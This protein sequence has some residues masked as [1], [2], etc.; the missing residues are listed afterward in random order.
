M[1]LGLLSFLS[2]LNSD[3]IAQDSPRIEKLYLSTDKDTYNIGEKIHFS[4]HLVHSF[5]LGKMEDASQ[6][7]YVELLNSRDS[8]VRRVKVKRDSLGFHNSLDLDKTM[9][10]GT[11]RL[12]AYTRWMMNFDPG[13]MHTKQIKIFNP[14]QKDHHG[15]K[16]QKADF[17]LQFFPESGHFLPGIWQN[18]A[19]KAIGSDGLGAD[20]EFIVLNTKGDTVST[21]SS[22]HLGM[23]CFKL[24]ATPGEHFTAIAECEGMKRKFAL[25]AVQESGIVLQCVEVKDQFICETKMTG[26][27]NP[28]DYEL[29]LS[30]RGAEMYRTGLKKHSTITKFDQ[31]YIPDGISSIFIYNR[32]TGEPVA[33]RLVF[34]N[35]GTS[36]SPLPRPEKPGMKKRAPVTLDIVLQD[37]DGTP[38]QGDFS[39][40]VTDASAVGAD[41]S[42]DNILTYLLMSSDIRGYIENPRYYFEN[43][44]NEKDI[45]LLLLTQGWSSYWRN[46]QFIKSQL[47]YPFEDDQVISGEV[48]GFWGNKARSP[49]LMLSELTSRLFEIIPLGETNGFNIHTDFP[50]STTYF[51]QACYKSGKVGNTLS[52]NIEPEVFAASPL[53]LPEGLAREETEISKEFEEQSL[54]SLYYSEDGAMYFTLEGTTITA[55]QEE[56]NSALSVL[57]SSHTVAGDDLQRFTG[58]TVFDAA[59]TFPSVS[60]SDTLRIRGGQDPVLFFVDDMPVDYTEVQTMMVSDVK[61]IQMVNGEEAQFLTADGSGGIFVIQLKDGVEVGSMETLPSFAKV[62]HL[63]WKKPDAFYQ[64][65]YEVDSVRNDVKPDLRTTLAWEPVVRTDAQGHA[66]VHFYANDFPVNYRVLIEGVT[67]NG[68]IIC[69]EA[70]IGK[71]IHEKQGK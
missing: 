44:E 3:V 35:N 31:A 4:G 36:I 2:A 33:Q 59:R 18:I 5:T 11:Y 54:Q 14:V 53:R 22:S 50:D 13:F 60:G 63:G 29:A 20:V 26:D 70:Y 7:I 27:L 71:K 25:P 24:N 49:Q 15:Y 64:P 45:D 43:K 68:K 69:S 42:A 41:R 55:E 66:Q 32:Q 56:D 34:V 46:D 19:F 52:L 28:E 48:L 51:L 67:V 16:K 58:M 47:N 8:L 40:A 65:K 30:C 1:T 12:R 61:S 57:N 6:F 38:L 39:L 9:P 17:D 23:G 37:H 21:C 10:Q 62:Q